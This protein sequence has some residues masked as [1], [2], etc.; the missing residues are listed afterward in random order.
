MKRAFARMLSICLLLA[1]AA[2]PAAAE[3][4]K[5]PGSGGPQSLLRDAAAAFAKAKPG[6][7]VEIPESVGTGGGYKAVGEGEAA[8]GRVTRPPK[9]KELDYGLEY[10]L[11]A[12]T[13]IVFHVHPGVKLKGLT[14]AQTVDLFTG[15]IANWKEVGGPDE[16]VRI[17]TRQPGESN[18]T[19]IQKAIPGWKDLVVT[20]RS[21][22]TN[23][24]Q[25]MPAVV[26]DNAGAIGFGPINEANDKG[27]LSLAIDGVSPLAPAYP[28]QSDLALIFRKDKL[29]PGMKAFID[30]LF[31]AEGEKIVRANAAT[32]VA[33]N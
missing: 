18:L 10:L 15:R 3:T 30:F 24:D 11:F 27:L 20:E 17:V 26:A 28:V 21:K 31:S 4:F 13:P 16:K 1:A 6:V 2:A 12:R 7:T 23:T 19:L 9:G 33:R 22:M 29:T 14:A 5:I 8:M 32:P 25:E